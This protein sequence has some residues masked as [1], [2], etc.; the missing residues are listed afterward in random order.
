[1]DLPIVLKKG[2]RSY[3]I[4]PISH[5]VSLQKLLIQHRAFSMLIHSWNSYNHW[6]SS[7]L[8]TMKGDYDRRNESIGEK[9]D[10]G[11]CGFAKKMQGHGM[12]M[13]LYH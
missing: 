8:G 12:Q 1:M 13:D 3:T 7:K 5:F 9:Q 6:G 10:L 11:D 2:A 4:H